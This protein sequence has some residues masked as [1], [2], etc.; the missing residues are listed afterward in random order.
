MAYLKAVSGHEMAEGEAPEPFEG[1]GIEV[2]KD[3]VKDAEDAHSDAR[4][5][6]HRDRDWYDNFDDTQWD[7]REKA[8]LK[9][10]GQPIV[11]MNRIKR[12]INFLCGIEQ[13]SRTDPK[14]Y[15]RKPGNTEQAQVATD[16]LD[17]IENTIR[18]DKIASASFKNLCIDGIAAVDVCYEERTGAYGVVA[19]EID[20]DQFF[21]DPRSRKPDFSDARYLG[22][23]NWYDLEDAQEM[24]ARDDEDKG[25]HAGGFHGHRDGQ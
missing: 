17:Y 5:L 16:V 1:K 8:I 25:G 19:K 14:A 6:A 11:T 3:W 22:Y 10:R 7:E 9:K 15:P 2:Y 18:F 20:F 21:Y 24:F 12:K 23:H 4:K 13:K